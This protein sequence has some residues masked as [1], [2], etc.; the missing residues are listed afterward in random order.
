MTSRYTNLEKLIPP[1]CHQ[2]SLFP[3][4]HL[5]S[6]CKAVL[7][8]P[9]HGTLL[10]AP[11]TTY[12]KAESKMLPQ[13]SSGKLASVSQALP[14]EK[15]LEETEMDMVRHSFAGMM[16]VL[17]HTKGCPFSTSYLGGAPSDIAAAPTVPPEM[18]C[19]ST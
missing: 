11:V 12:L 8:P 15:R 17:I 5:S 1:P 16:P 19:S 18:P 7:Q 4:P 10:L 3:S 14:T 6:D 9:G 2:L 13:R